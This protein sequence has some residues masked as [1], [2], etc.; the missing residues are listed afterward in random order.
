MIVVVDWVVATTSSLHTTPSYTIDIRIRIRPHDRILSTWR[1]QIAVTWHDRDSALSRAEF[2]IKMTVY[3][4]CHFKTIIVCDRVQTS[5]T[6]SGR[7]ECLEFVQESHV[8]IDNVILFL[9]LFYLISNFP[10]KFRKFAIKYYRVT[11]WLHLC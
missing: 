10:R 9:C 7:L 11:L 8:V 6:I 1:H 4:L 3:L 5:T 2:G